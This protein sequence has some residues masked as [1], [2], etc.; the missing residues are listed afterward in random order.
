M[1]IEQVRRVHIFRNVRKKLIIAQFVRRSQV[2][3]K[4][5]SRN[6]YLEVGLARASGHQSHRALAR[7]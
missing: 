6:S 4:F 3:L 1:C 2:G 5:N 7:I